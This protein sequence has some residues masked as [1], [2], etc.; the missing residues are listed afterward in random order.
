MSNCIYH[1]LYY[2]FI[3]FLGDDGDVVSEQARA[4]DKAEP[5]DGEFKKLI[6]FSG[7]DYLGLSSHPMVRDAASKACL[8]APLEFFQLY[9]IFVCYWCTCIYLNYDH[10]V[11][12][13]RT[14]N[15]S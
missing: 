13:S 3:E 6:V 9:I 2:Q 5:S 10:Y 15:G 7:N 12:S 11:G 4:T 14:W 1:F 8:N